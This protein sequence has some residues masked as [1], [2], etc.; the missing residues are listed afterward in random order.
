VAV[1]DDGPGIPSE[2]HQRVFQPFYQ[3]ASQG[4][5]GS[6][7]GLGLAICREIVLRHK[8]EIWF[9]SELGTGSKF[10]F[11]MPLHFPERTVEVEETP[12]KHEAGRV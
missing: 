7:T 1:V 3:G 8:G 12:G 2:D 10:Y 9:E 4:P 6:G 11:T 5:S